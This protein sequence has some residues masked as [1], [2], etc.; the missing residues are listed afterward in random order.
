MKRHGWLVLAKC[1]L[2]TRGN[3]ELCSDL[4][5]D[6][7]MSLWVRFGTL[8][9]DC[10]EGE[11]RAWVRYV[12]S[13]VLSHYDRTRRVVTV[14]LS[15]EM[16][17]LPDDD[18]SEQIRERLEECIALLDEDEA[19]L[20][21]MRIEGYSAEEIAA[22]LGIARNAVYQ[23]MHRIVKLLRKMLLAVLLL[24]V[25]AMTAIALVPQWRQAVFPHVSR[26]QAEPAPAAP[27]RQPEPAMTTAATEPAAPP[28]RTESDAP[29]VVPPAAIDAM[30]PLSPMPIGDVAEAGGYEPTQQSDAAMLEASR[31]KPG[32]ADLI[33]GKW[34]DESLNGH[35][36]PFLESY[37]DYRPDGTV[38]FYNNLN[39]I[40]SIDT[41]A[42]EVN[43]NILFIKDLKIM[44]R[45]IELT[46]STMIR[47]F[48]DDG[49]R[50]INSMVRV[51]GDK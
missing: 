46:D 3:S 6:V 43:G 15:P 7:C 33:L 42:Y 19:K 50:C 17:S 16:A 36:F 31:R 22:E 48:S 38:V 29:A 49:R 13:S 10:T 41:F 27:V 32:Y 45:I 25:S 4:V 47:E 8:R 12:T 44:D 24:V 26:R 40:L 35:V 21:N 11:E 20:V 39:G 37:E 34:F 2:R 30:V 51:I 9:E 1:R 5:Q 28:Q 23:R 18:A 14:P